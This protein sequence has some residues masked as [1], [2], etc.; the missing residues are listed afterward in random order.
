MGLHS[1]NLCCSRVACIQGGGNAE[2]YDSYIC[3]FLRN[4]HTL[5]HSGCA[6]LYFQQLCTK[7]PFPNSLAKRVITWL[8]DNSCANRHEVIS[9]SGVGC[10]LPDG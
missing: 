1:S 6:N 2:S 5:F 10:H 8:F 4:L 9:Y 7:F 3:D